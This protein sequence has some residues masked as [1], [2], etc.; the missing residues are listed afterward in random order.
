MLLLLL[1]RVEEKRFLCSC[2]SVATAAGVDDG[3]V[4]SMP[5]TRTTTTTKTTTIDDRFATAVAQTIKQKQFPTF[6]KEIQVFQSGAKSNGIFPIPLSHRIV[7]FLLFNKQ[8]P[9]K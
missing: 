7:S 2:R 5:P 6:K 4:P 9:A 1:L 3:D 8:Q